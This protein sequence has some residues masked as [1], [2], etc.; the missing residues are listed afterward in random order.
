MDRATDRVKKSPGSLL[1]SPSLV[2]T[3]RNQPAI[4]KIDRYR[5][6]AKEISRFDLCISRQHPS[7]VQKDNSMIF[8]FHDFSRNSSGG[9]KLVRELTVDAFDYCCIFS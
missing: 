3:A 8:Y 7:L 4:V 2:D 5:P 6:T 1:L 9:N